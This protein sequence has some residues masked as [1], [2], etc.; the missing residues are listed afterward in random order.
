MT[1]LVINYSLESVANSQKYGITNLPIF[2]KR[3]YASGEK[4]VPWETFLCKFG[5]PDFYESATDSYETS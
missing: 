4:N 1:N 5:F 2:L 3:V